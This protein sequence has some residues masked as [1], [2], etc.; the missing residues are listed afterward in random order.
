VRQASFDVCRILCQRPIAAGREDKIS[1]AFSSG[2]Y[3]VETN[4][5][6]PGL[7][8]PAADPTISAFRANAAA[9]DYSRILAAGSPTGGACGFSFDQ[10]PD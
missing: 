3:F 10:R 9:A 4:G 6:G 8:T 1:F 7:A 2:A 5:G